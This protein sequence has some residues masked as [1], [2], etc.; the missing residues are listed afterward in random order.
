MKGLVAY[1]FMNG[2]GNFI[3]ATAAVKVLQQWGYKVDLITDE[4][5]LTSPAL[6]EIS[7]GVFNSI[8]TEYDQEKYLKTFIASWS[9]PRLFRDRFGNV[10]AGVVNWD[11]L[12]THEVQL[13]LDT[14]GAD[15]Q[16]YDG[17]I[18]KPAEVDFEP[19]PVKIT[20]ALSN[21]A[22]TNTFEKLHIGDKQKKRYPHFPELSRTLIGLGYEVVLVGL[23]GELGDSEGIDFTSQLTVKETAGVIKKCD[24]LI[25]PSTGNT[26]LADAVGT[27]VLLLEGPMQTA[28]AH[29]INVPYSILR[30][31]R[32][33]APCF[34]KSTWKHCKEP[35]CMQDM[36]PNKV[37]QHLL[38]FLPHCKQERIINI[39]PIEIKKEEPLEC[40]RRVAYLVACYNRHNVLTTFLDSFKNSNLVD[41]EF[42]FLDDDSSDPRVW[43][44][45]SST[46]GSFSLK[47]HLYLRNAIEKKE[48]RES[49]HVNSSIHAYNYLLNALYKELEKGNEFDYV[50]LIDPD[51]I[52]KPNWIQKMIQLYE[53]NPDLH[54][55]MVSPFNTNHP[56]YDKNGMSEVQDTIVGS[57]RLREGCNLPYMISIDFLKDVHGLFALVG[58][59][60]SDLGKSKELTEK[61][62]SAMITVPSLVEHY[63][64]YATALNIT[65]GVITSEDFYE[66]I[67]PNM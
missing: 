32:S 33:C 40:K 41:G 11:K 51:I 18:F 22:V 64:A 1:V 24:L 37:I 38:E 57:F 42:F 4:R 63:G 44:L 54:I 28:R 29:P 27:P 19:D 25:A 36:R 12:G 5:F 56:V 30:T 45:L 31:Y 6:C 43:D 55:G 66:S 2:L 21:C 16:D 59:K 52:M 9:I 58:M 65:K 13:Y 50:I 20:I 39:K 26:V 62:F 17:Y 8:Q 3:F 46:L 49:Y 7:E 61:G 35:A 48:I 14:I 10:Q 23:E 47:G 67:M 60:S 34:Q 53:L 15:W